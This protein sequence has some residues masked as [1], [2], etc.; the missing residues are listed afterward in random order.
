VNLNTRR[1]TSQDVANLAGVSRTTVSLV[2]NNVEGFKIRRDTRQR[3]IKAAGELGY[4]PDAAAQALASRRARIIG[5]I[6]TRF[7]HHISTDAF[8]TQILEGLF[9]IIHQNDMRLLIDIIEPEHQH[10]AYLQLVRANRIDG[11]LLSGPRLDDDALRVLET[12]NFP[13]VL[14]GQLPNATFCSVDVDN[15]AA[16]KVAVAHLIRL[17][18]E[19]IAFISNAHFTY[20]AALD[21]K[22]G[23]RIALIEAGIPYD[24][25]LVR[26]GDFTVGSGYQEM[27]NLLDSNLDFSAV[28]VASDIVALGAK[29]A[30]LQHGFK[31]PQ[32]IALVGFDDLPFSQYVD[33]PLTTVHLPTTDL[34]RRA[35]ELLIKLLEGEQP[36]NNHILLETNLVIRESCG[37]I[38][39]EI[40]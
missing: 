10:E 29:S 18:H 6:L 9:D 15:R 40:L 36:D 11:I 28:F 39:N 2:L 7:P 8:I 23:Y 26:S 4:V 14:I 22:E 38:L 24:E 27:T 31:I 30:I 35:T 34:A 12:E 33:P 17:G 25:N 21:R 32:D 13:T 37:A 1:V 3:V 5:L 16:A 19:R 20:T